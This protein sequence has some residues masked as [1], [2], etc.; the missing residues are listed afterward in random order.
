MKFLL[1]ESTSQDPE[2]ELT[3][4]KEQAE[5]LSFSP[6]GSPFERTNALL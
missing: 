2:L 6:M 4:K 3:E 1:C 5:D